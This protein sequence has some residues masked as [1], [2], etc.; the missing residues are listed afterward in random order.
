[1]K[2]IPYAKVIGELERL[3]CYTRAEKGNYEFEI[4]TQIANVLINESKLIYT[5]KDEKNTIF[6]IPVR[7]NYHAINIIKLWKETGI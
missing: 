1:M 5:S 2:D 6:G 7:L 3:Y 4:G